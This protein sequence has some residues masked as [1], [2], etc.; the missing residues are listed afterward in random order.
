MFFISQF[1]HCDTG[2]YTGGWCPRNVPIFSETFPLSLVQTL[3]SFVR[4][5]WTREWDSQ[6][7]Y[8]I[9]IS[10]FFILNKEGFV[11]QVLIIQAIKVMLIRLFCLVIVISI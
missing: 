9:Y 1:Y 11:F 3:G 10:F 4:D 6:Y 7:I 8:W 5:V 2:T